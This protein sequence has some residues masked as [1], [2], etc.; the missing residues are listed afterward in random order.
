MEPL[1][2]G[3]EEKRAAVTARRMAALA[4]AEE[5]EGEG[6]D[7]DDEE[8]EEFGETDLCNLHSSSAVVQAR[9]TT[10]AEV[11]FEAANVCTWLSALGNRPVDEDQSSSRGARAPFR[12]LEPA[13]VGRITSS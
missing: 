9:R 2:Q 12:F 11:E 3:E 13:L 6:E 8:E 10:A 4:L 7:E 1:R 5:D